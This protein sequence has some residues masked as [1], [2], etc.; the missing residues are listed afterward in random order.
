ML[1]DEDGKEERRKVQRRGKGEGEPARSVRSP[2][3]LSCTPTNVLLLQVNLSV[4]LRVSMCVP[5]SGRV[6]ATE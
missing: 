2:M 4:L 1:C 5:V 6:V 3:L